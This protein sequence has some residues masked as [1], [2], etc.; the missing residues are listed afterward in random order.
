MSGPNSQSRVGFGFWIAWV[1]ASGAG[2]ALQA[3]L[4]WVAGDVAPYAGDE[5][6][7]V[8]GLV[9]GFFIGV[10]QWLVLRSVLREAGWWILA[11]M[12]G[13][14]IGEVSALGVRE[15][16]VPLVYMAAVS[17][18]Q[19]VVLQGHVRYSGWWVP[20]NAFAMWLHSVLGGRFGIVWGVSI[21]TF[22]EDTLG[23]NL[24]PTAVDTGLLVAETMIGALCGAI[25]G[26]LLVWLLS[27]SKE[28]PTREE[29][30]E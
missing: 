15:Q 29:P 14:F 24:G 10:T 19:W 12:A 4:A 17:L 5:V 26:A 2:Y 22:L 6:W 27:H 16:W 9:G 8:Y 28:A 1:L 30:T 18:A 23:L 13:Y 21:A 20:V 3:W 25:T 7:A 11:C